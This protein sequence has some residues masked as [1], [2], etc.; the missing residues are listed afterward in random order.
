MDV[1]KVWALSYS[2]TGNTAKAVHTVAEALARALNVPLAEVS[3]TT[4]AERAQ[5]YIFTPS[6]LVVVGSPT[7]AGRLPNKIAPDLRERL[8]GGGALAAAIVTFGNRAFDNSLAELAALLADGGFQVLAAG[9][10][11]GQHAFTDNLAKGRPNS[12][13]HGELK[14]FG[15]TVAQKIKDGLLTAPT[16]PGNPEA[17]YYVPLGT[18]GQPAKFLKAKPQTDIARCDNC[19]DCARLCPMGAIDPQNNSNVQGICIKCQRCVRYCSKQAKYFDD[20]A[21]LSH[22]AMLEKDFQEPKTNTTFL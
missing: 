6:D 22:I 20:P 14:T 13:D 18:D 12:G 9:A 8:Q 3:F 4:L 10:F 1:Q 19:G 21:F 5:E 17:A 2:A 11:V 7:Y 16:V 15:E